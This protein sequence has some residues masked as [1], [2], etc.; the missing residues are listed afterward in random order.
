MQK[1]KEPSLSRPERADFR[2][3]RV[4]F[5]PKRADFRPERA[6]GEQTDKGADGMTNESPSVF[7]RTSSP[8][9]PLPCFPSLQF[10]IT[11]SRAM[12][13]ADHILPLG[14]LLCMCLCWEGGWVGR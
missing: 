2:P 9:G 13:I 10:T 1:E 8:S 11:Q 6:W 5:R 3:E 7:Y 12:G 14:D 4:N